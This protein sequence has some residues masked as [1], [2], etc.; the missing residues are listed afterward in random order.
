MKPSTF[1]IIVKIILFMYLIG[2]G[3]YAVAAM[4]KWVD[5]DGNTHYTQSPPPAGAKGQ[6]IKPPPRVDSEAAAKSLE[7]QQQNLDQLAADRHKQGEAAQKGAKEQ[8]EQ[9]RICEQARARAA[10]YERPRVTL[11]EKDGSQRRATEEERLA[12]LAEAN[13]QV[14]ENCK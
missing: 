13:K 5:A 7:Q 4:Y 1:N 14:A 6:E 12:K 2:T 8:S 9:K 10:S 11:N 3:S